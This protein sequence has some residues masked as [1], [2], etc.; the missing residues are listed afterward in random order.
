[1]MMAGDMSPASMNMDVLE[2][3]LGVG[4]RFVCAHSMKFAPFCQFV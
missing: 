1:M 4:A 3:V 2:Y